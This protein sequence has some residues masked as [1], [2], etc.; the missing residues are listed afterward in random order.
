VFTGLWP[1]WYTL[2]VIPGLI[3][4]CVNGISLGMRALSRHSADRRHH[5]PNDVLLTPILWHADQIPG[6][7]MLVVFN[8]FYYLVEVIRQPLLGHP[9]SLLIWSVAAGMTL[10]GFI[11]ALAFFSRFRN[12]IVYWL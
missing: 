10:I 8:P 1:N 2:L 12:R 11:V 6:R 5:H 7:R 3:L 4:I 9:P